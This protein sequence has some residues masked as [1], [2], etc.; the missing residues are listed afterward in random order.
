MDGTFVEF[1]YR[2]LEVMFER[3]LDVVFAEVVVI[4]HGCDRTA[5]WAIDAGEA[6]ESKT[7]V[8]RRQCFAMVPLAFDLG[9]ALN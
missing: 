5:A 7:N 2:D 8:F 6:V 4:F 3:L 9:F 1:E